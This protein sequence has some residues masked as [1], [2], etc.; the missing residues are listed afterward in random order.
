MSIYFQRSS[1]SILN[2]TVELARCEW[3]LE[4]I[5]FSP[6]AKTCHQS[7][8]ERERAIALK[9]EERGGERERDRK[10]P[11]EGCVQL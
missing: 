10:I 1:T 11:R 3:H 8:R 5:L 2:D 6:R 9:K 7:E 4:K